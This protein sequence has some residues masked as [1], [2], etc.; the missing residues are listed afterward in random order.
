LTPDWTLA[1]PEPPESSPGRSP[2]ATTGPQWLNFCIRHDPAP[3]LT[4]LATLIQVERLLRAPGWRTRRNAGQ[5]IEGW[6][7]A[8]SDHP[9]ALNFPE[10][11]YLK[12]LL[13]HVA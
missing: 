5:R 9:V 12:G 1:V 13:C 7:H 6:L 4:A 10:G 8:A 3:G 11:E 2:I